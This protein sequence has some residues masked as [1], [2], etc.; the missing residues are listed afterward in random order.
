MNAAAA[1]LV[2]ASLERVV[3]SMNGCTQILAKT[4]DEAADASNEQS[5]AMARWTKVM[6]ITSIALTI[7]ALA[8]VVVAVLEFLKP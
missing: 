3:E 1:K 5:A 2:A 7:F 6:G 4:V 8:Q